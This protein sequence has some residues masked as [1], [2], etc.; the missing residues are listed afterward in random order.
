MKN[1]LITAFIVGLIASIAFIIFQPLFGLA[2]LTSRHAAAYVSFGG[3]SE[4][5]ALILSW[6]V[7][8]S[9][10]IAYAVISTV[11]FNFNHSL[12]VS[13]AQVIVLGW[14]T[15]LIATPANE[16]VVKLVT[17]ETFTP[18][19]DLAPLNTAIGPKLWLHVMFFVFVIFG[20]WF[21]KVKIDKK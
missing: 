21:K 6:F 2:T 3:Y 17:T 19:S 11:I 8:I 15:T 4:I 1:T 18:L 7:H 10:S 20:L 14:F 5:A 9:V 12:W 13:S 16:W